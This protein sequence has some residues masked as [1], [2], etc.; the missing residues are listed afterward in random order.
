MSGSADGPADGPAGP[1]ARLRLRRRAAFRRPTRA[2]RRGLSQ[3]ICA[4]AGLL[5]GMVAPM[6]AVGPQVEAG[7][8]VSLLFTIGFGVISLVSIIYSML[9]LVVQFSASTFTPRLGLFRDEPI[10][11]R[12]FAFTVGVF[13]F[14]VTSGLTIG[15][16]PGVSAFVPVTAMVLALVAIVFMRTLQMKAFDSIQLGHSL[17]AIATR[18]HLLFDELYAQPFVQ[19]AG[20]VGDPHPET[21]RATGATA[22]PWSGAAVVLQQFDVPALVG[23]AREHD[24]TIAFRVAPGTTLSR[25]IELAGVSAGGLSEERLR[26]ALLTGVERTFDQDPELPFRLLADIALRALSPAVNDPATAVDALDR[27]EDL[28]TRL[29][30]RELDI[31]RFHDDAGRLRVTIPVPGWEQFVRTSVDDVVFAAAGSP[32]AL[33]RM[34]DLLRGLAE[35][36]PEGRRGVVRDR[37][38][39]VERTGEERY[40]LVWTAPG[41]GY[42]HGDAG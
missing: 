10:V 30:G 29:A 15:V 25:G 32:M 33:R 6:V 17:T 35:R 36:A 8:V 24:C 23:A 11:W 40:P 20:A 26:G 7:R 38:R 37:L 22:V 39:W 3:L 19:P 12:T 13:V 16:G 5:L 21:A 42:G 28:L 2:M 9:F 4:I 1:G 41:G 27:L 18:A 14:C 31:G 34:R